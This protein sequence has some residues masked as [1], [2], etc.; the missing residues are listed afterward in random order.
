MAAIEMPLAL[1]P[2]T[3]MAPDPAARMEYIAAH[4][5]LWRAGWCLW[6]AAAL[7][8]LGFIVW[9]AA[10]VPARSLGIA[11][12][13]VAIAGIGGDLLGESLYVGWL[14]A[15]DDRI[16]SLARLLT[17]A[18]GNTLY[19]LA[20][21]LLTIGS[22]WIVG[23]ARACAWAAWTAGLALSAFS[24]A[25]HTSGMAVAMALLFILFCPWVVW[26]GLLSTAVERRGR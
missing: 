24:L 22:P 21:I 26:M 8:L 25:G 11:A 1:A 23:P 9:W 17:G 10:R 13:V 7:S 20:G 6:I 15:G 5:W 16:A 19:T 2:G 4:P 12:L 18:W 14:P 3:E